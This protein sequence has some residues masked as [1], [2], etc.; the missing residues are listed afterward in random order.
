MNPLI[1]TSSNSAGAMSPEQRHKLVVEWN[2]NAS[3]YPRHLCIHQVFEQEAARRPNAVAVRFEDQTLTYRELNERANQ[4]AHRLRE[5]GVG[6][7]VMVGTVMDRSL[8]MVIALLGILKAGGAFVP[9]DL[10]YPAERLAFM[11]SDTKAPVLV[12]G[13]KALERLSGQDWLQAQ[14]VMLDN[15]AGE[16]NRKSKTNPENL[17]SPTGLAYVMYTSGST[18]RPKGV[19]VPHRAVVRLVKNTNFLEFRE[20][21]VFLQFSPISFD[22]STLEIW[23]PLLNGGCVAVASPCT[24]SLEEIGGEIRKHGVTTAWLTAGLFNLMVE[25]RLDDLKPLR[26]LLAGGDTLSVPHVKQALE[27]LP[28]CRLVNGYGP[29][30]GTTFTCCHTMT[31]EDI[32]G[33]SIPIGRPIANTQVY[34]LDANYDPVAAGEEGELYAGGDGVARG[35]LNQPELTAERFIRNPFSDD[36][37][38]RLYKTGDLARYRADG[39]IEFLGRIDH[40]VKISGYRIELGEIEAALI[41]HPDVKNAV[42]IARQDGPGQKKLLAYVVPKNGTYSAAELRSYLEQ[43]LPPYMLPSALMSLEVLPLSPNGKVD[44]GALPS[45][46]TEQATITGKASDTKTELEQKI[47]AVWGK[48]L[49]LQEVG[50]EVNFFDIGGDS[51]ALLEVHAELQKAVDPQI[52]VVDLFDYTTVRGLAQKLIGGAQRNL[53]AAQDRAQ[54]QRAAWERQKAIRTF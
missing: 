14:L 25:Q 31:V 39:V 53:Q 10:N 51:L 4:L 3:D 28:H 41:G 54:Q 46:G 44:R 19:M 8:E 40:Q 23:G 29:T 37:N 5:L 35:Y 34:L 36:P 43:K 49:G 30:E 17:T 16:I 11:A 2:N 21:D 27:G 13:Q 33:T 52:Q 15:N 9:L 38:A 50:L 6:P 24:H 48:V 47:A 18:G 22:A 7:E 32:Q 42:V 45:P 20:N 26:Q 12:V 1:T